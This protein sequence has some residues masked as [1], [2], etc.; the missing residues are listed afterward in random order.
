M[1]KYLHFLLLLPLSMLALKGQSQSLPDFQSGWLFLKLEDSSTISL[2][3]YPGN[4]PVLNT[5]FAT[6][7]LDTIYDPF[8]TQHPLL[9][10]IYKLSFTDTLSTNLLITALEALP[11]VDYAEQIPAYTTTGVNY[12]PNDMVGQQWFLNK[13]QAPAAWD[14]ARGSTNVKVAIVDNA[15]RTTHEDLAPVIWTNPGEIPNNLLDD[16]LNGYPD[17][18]NGWDAGD[19]DKN[20]N[21]PASADDNSPWVHGSHCAGI[22][23]A[24]TDNGTGIASIGFGISII[25]VKVS[26]WLTGGSAIIAAEEGIDYAIAADADV[27]SMSFGSAG[28]SL[29]S[30]RVMQAAVDNDIVLIAGA[31]NNDTETM[32]YPA[33]YPEVLAVGATNMSDQKSGYSNYGSWIDVMAPGNSIYSTM[34]GTDTTYASLSGTSMAC[35]L[36]AGLAG[37]IRSYNPG[38]NEQ[39]VKDAII[40]GCVNIDSLNPSYQTKLGAGRINAMNSLNLATGIELQDPASDWVLWPNPAGEK[41]YLSPRQGNAGSGDWEMLDLSGRRIAGGQLNGTRFEYG[42]S[43]IPSGVYLIRVTSPAGSFH[44]KLVIHH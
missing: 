29:T 19:F 38:L 27:I 9:N 31:G 12:V 11:F 16:D 5:I 23:G 17:D 35:P 24:A 33:A 43:A 36:T 34:G 8:K 20:P 25:P 30:Q 28:N 10:Q 4:I 37:L 15:V 22:A 39:E 40:N 18:V 41:I 13:I 6:Y 2:D 3:P 44:K 14:I 21:P 42:V 26:S 7:G 32:F 1:R